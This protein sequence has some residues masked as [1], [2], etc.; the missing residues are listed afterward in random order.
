VAFVSRSACKYFQNYLN[1]YLNLHNKA[2]IPYQYKNIEPDTKINAIIFL[3]EGRFACGGSTGRLFIINLTTHETEG[4]IE[5]HVGWGVNSIS[6]ADGLLASASND[7]F[8][9]FWTIETLEYFG[10]LKH[11]DA[12]RDV[13]MKVYDTKL[14]G[15]ISCSDDGTVILTTPRDNCKELWSAKCHTDWCFGVDFMFH[16]LQLF[17]TSCAADQTI[18]IWQGIENA[19]SPDVVL[20]DFST[21]ALCVCFGQDPSTVYSGCANN[22]VIMWDIEN[23]T[24][25]IKMVFENN[26]YNGEIQSILLF[27]SY[28]LSASSDNMIRVWDIAAGKSVEVLKSHSASVN[29]VS[30]LHESQGEYSIVSGSDDCKAVLWQ[31]DLL[32]GFGEQADDTEIPLQHAIVV[33]CLLY[34]N[35]YIYVGSQNGSVHVFDLVM[36]A[37]SQDDC[38]QVHSCKVSALCCGSTILVSGD[39]GGLVLL[40]SKINFNL[41]HRLVGH[42]EAVT[43]LTM[44]GE[45]TVVSC[46]VD[47]NLIVWDSNSGDHLAVLKGHSNSVNC[48]A[49]IESLSALELSNLILSGSNDGSL[50]KF[51]DLHFKY[52]KVRI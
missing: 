16:Q 51:Q 48:I 7:G 26:L 22:S 50:R 18:H 23:S 40:W 41:L 11:Q 2:P 5:A 25:Q 14:L 46:A 28:L 32:A 12:V 19:S 43:G 20:K 47:H 24:G 6:Y 52:L 17:I 45:H 42:S 1:T 9:K 27:S 49:V 31:L 21:T 34:D 15:C 29:A 36:E 35:Q 13:K 10:E 33:T 44:V 38:M 3:D 8:V 39:S 37:F 4:C 30:V